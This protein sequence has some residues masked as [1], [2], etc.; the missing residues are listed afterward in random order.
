MKEVTTKLFLFSE[1]SKDVQETIARKECDKEYGVSY[2]NIED[3][4]ECIIE[5]TTAHLASMGFN[6][7]K[8]YYRITCSQGDGACFDASID[9]DILFKNEE[10]LKIL[11]RYLGKNTQRFVK[12][13][14]PYVGYSIQKNNYGHYYCHETTRYIESEIS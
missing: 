8:I 12:Y 4:F 11:V 10:F 13:I 5:D 7:V 1:L 14:L 3:S 9:S 6:D 2:Y